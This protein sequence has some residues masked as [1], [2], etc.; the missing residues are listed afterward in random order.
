MS[1]VNLRTVVLSGLGCVFAT[2][3][4]AN[5]RGE[6][7]MQFEFGVN[8][9]Q[10]EAT[11]GERVAFRT[12]SPQPVDPAEASNSALTMSLR[13]TG[14][15]AYNMFFGVEGEVGEILGLNDSNVAGA[16]GIAGARADVGRLRMGI[17]MAAG[18]RWIRYALDG[19]EDASVMMAEPRVRADLWVSPRFTLGGAAGA[20]LG[21]RS[22]WMAGVYIGLHSQDFDL[23]R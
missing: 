22:V 19:R 15:T 9:R 20:T 1:A 14:R 10:F 21:E 4:F 17:E 23:R 2:T 3:A 12:M 18:R 7:P 13:F 16:Y 6:N 8:T 5:P 11:E